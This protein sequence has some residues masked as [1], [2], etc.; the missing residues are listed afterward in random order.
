M[1]IVPAPGG[2]GWTL[3][4]VSEDGPESRWYE[5]RCEALRYAFVTRVADTNTDRLVA[6]GPVD[7]YTHVTGR[8]PQDGDK[9]RMEEYVPGL[10][11]H[12]VKECEFDEVEEVVGPFIN[13]RAQLVEVADRR[14]VR[15][16][17]SAARAV[18]GPGREAVEQMAVL[19]SSERTG[20]T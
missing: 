15:G 9:D 14:G 7:F 17:L 2:S 20:E 19:S 6:C 1:P 8:R 5:R 12:L 3:L 11:K 13:R 10:I 16:M 18:L 4:V